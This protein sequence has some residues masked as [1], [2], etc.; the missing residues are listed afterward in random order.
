MKVALSAIVSRFDLLPVDER[1]AAR[2]R[3]GITL[4]PKG[5]GRVRLGAYAPV[6][7]SRWPL[8]EARN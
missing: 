4:V 5:G 2:V 1:P 3:R 8:T 6:Q 7:P